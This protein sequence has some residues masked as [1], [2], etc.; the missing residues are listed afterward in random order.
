MC[1]ISFQVSGVKEVMDSLSKKG[2]KFTRPLRAVTSN[3]KGEL[4]ATDFRDPD[5]HVLSITG[6]V[7][8]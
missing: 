2:V 8:R 5:G 3:D 6:W 4:L 1:E 7:A